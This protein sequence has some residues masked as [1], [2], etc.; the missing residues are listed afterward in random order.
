MHIFQ[1]EMATITF[2]MLS[3]NSLNGNI[4]INSYQTQLLQIRTLLQNHVT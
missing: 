1:W 3:E 4:R 2:S